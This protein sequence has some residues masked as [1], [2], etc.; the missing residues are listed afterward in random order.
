M[1]ILHCRIPGTEESSTIIAFVLDCFI[2]CLMVVV[3]VLV[4]FQW[5]GTSVSAAAMRLERKDLLSVV[6]GQVWTQSL[7]AALRR[8]AQ[9]R[10][11]YCTCLFYKHDYLR[12]DHICA[13]LIVWKVIKNNNMEDYWNCSVLYCV[14]QSCAVVNTFFGVNCGLLV[15]PWFRFFAHLF[16]T[17]ASYFWLFVYFSCFLWVWLSM[18]SMPG[19]TSLCNE[20][21]HVECYI[22][23]HSR[24]HSYYK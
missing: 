3:M 7:S 24:T 22:K 4:V 18:Q 5:T 14:P 11:L 13:M 19:N 23:L 1:C 15:R 2:C 9:I 8:W 10:W 12:T 20:L 21:Q 6:P 17:G 16:L